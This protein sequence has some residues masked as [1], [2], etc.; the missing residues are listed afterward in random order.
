MNVSKAQLRKMLPTSIATKYKDIDQDGTMLWKVIMDN[1]SN[2]A[3]KQQ[4]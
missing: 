1:L 4:V 3:T 2:K